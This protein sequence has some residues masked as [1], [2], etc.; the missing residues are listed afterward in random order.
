MEQKAVFSDH[1]KDYQK[2]FNKKLIEYSKEE[3]WQ[4]LEVIIT[5]FTVIFF[6]VFAVRPAVITIFDLIGEI[7][8][9][10]VLTQRMQNKIDT[11]VVAQEEFAFVQQRRDVL[12]SYLPFDFGISQGIVQVAGASQD[13]NLVFSQMNLSGVEM[14]DPLADLSGLEFT[15]STDGDYEELKNLMERLN[16]VRR[17]IDIDSYQISIADERDQALTQLRFNLRANF[18]YWFEE[19]YWFGDNNGER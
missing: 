16:Q 1:I 18:N 5:L 7:N 17:W 13:N 2:K 15:F 19:S 11:I 8:E 9:K 12:E 10:R 6:L 4:Y 14:A 3:N